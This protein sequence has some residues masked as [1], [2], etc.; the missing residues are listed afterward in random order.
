MHD[1]S[2]ETVDICLYSR[3]NRINAT[4]VHREVPT[5]AYNGVNRFDFLP[6]KYRHRFPKF[7]SIA[8][9]FSNIAFHRALLSSNNNSQQ[10][11]I[12]TAI[13]DCIEFCRNQN[14][15]IQLRQ[16]LL[17]SKARIFPIRQSQY[18][19]EIRSAIPSLIPTRIPLPSIQA[20]H[21]AGRHPSP[22]PL[23][24][25]GSFNIEARARA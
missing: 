3:C 21:A 1:R 18:A 7:Q 6:P 8:P 24:R 16:T 14:L 17:I 19:Y 11:F 10:L 5:L 13:R 22:R 4:P 12:Q 2:N 23:T 20:A 15:P 9:S 25:H